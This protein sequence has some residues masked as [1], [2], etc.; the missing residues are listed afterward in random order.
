M[1][2]SSILTRKSRTAA[3]PSRMASARHAARS[4][5]CV[6][7]LKPARAVA[8]HRRLRRQRQAVRLRNC[9]EPGQRRPGD[10]LAAAVRRSG[11]RGQ[12]KVAG[13][14]AAAPHDRQHAPGPRQRATPRTRSGTLKAQGGLRPAARPGQRILDVDHAACVGPDLDLL[15]RHGGPGGG[16]K[17]EK[18]DGAAHWGRGY[19]RAGARSKSLDRTVSGAWTPWPHPRA[20]GPCRD[21]RVRA[22]A[23][24]TIT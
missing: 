24:P 9:V 19:Q 4:K 8:V 20:G 12:V 3:K 22:C 11:N 2:R 7:R 14:N 23:T 10:H 6:P 15:A 1:L 21:V 18:E 16:E 13:L 5:A 17:K